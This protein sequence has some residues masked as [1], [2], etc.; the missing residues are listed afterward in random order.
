MDSGASGHVAGD[1]QNF[2][3]F[4]PSS[5]IQKVRTVGGETHGIEGLGSSIVK[6]KTGE[7]KLTNVKYVP[8][9]TKNLISVGAIVDTSN[10]V[11]F[12]HTYYFIIDAH[13][14]SMI[15]SG[16]RNPVNGLH[17]IENVFE[18]NSIEKEDKASLWHR[19]FGHLSYFGLGH[20]AKTQTVT[21]LSKID[22]YHR[23]CEHCLADKQHRERFPR[24]STNMASETV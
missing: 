3:Y 23:V 12:T 11:I 13:N 7:I 18:I 5:S 10:L 19:C 6:T 15:A 2:E 16:T 21:G 1:Y 4:Q 9:L 8:S 20:L 22:P 17:N 14:H 24:Q